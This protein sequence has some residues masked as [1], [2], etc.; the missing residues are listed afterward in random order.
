M[1]LAIQMVFDFLNEW[2]TQHSRQIVR[3]QSQLQI[4]E[5][6]QLGSLQVP[7][8]PFQGFDWNKKFGTSNSSNGGLLLVLWIN[9]YEDTISNNC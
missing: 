6:P 9:F 1:I 2:S 5:D 4:I 7:Q 8:I 3:F